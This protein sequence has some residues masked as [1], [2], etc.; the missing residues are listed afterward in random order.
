MKESKQE[1]QRKAKG[2]L[3][4]LKGSKESAVNRKQ[5]DSAHEETHVV[6]PTTRTN[7]VNQGAHPLLLQNRR[8]RALGKIL[9]K[10]SLSEVGVRHGRDLVDG[11]KTTLVGNARTPRVI[12]GILLCGQNYKSESGYS[13]CENAL[14]CKERLTV[15]KTEVEE[16]WWKR[17]SCLV[18]EFQETRFRIPQQ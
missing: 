16:K 6:S 1:H 15:S 7:V 5:K 12:L 3:S 10:E 9:R 14:L 17:I 2:K 18:Q 13:F 8:L 4:A 11:A